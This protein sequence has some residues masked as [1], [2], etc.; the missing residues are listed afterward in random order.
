MRAPSQPDPRQLPLFLEVIET[1]VTRDRPFEADDG[2]WG[3]R[4]ARPQGRGW[5]V[6]DFSH[7]RKTTWL[8]RRPVVPAQ[9]IS[10]RWR[11]R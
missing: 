8:R 10:G 3:S 4:I 7:D 11:R 2:A 6:S 1:T 9:R 5:R